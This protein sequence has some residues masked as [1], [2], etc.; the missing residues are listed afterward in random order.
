MFRFCFNVA[1]LFVILVGFS[2]FTAGSVFVVGRYIEELS[3]PVYQ[4]ASSATYYYI[5]GHPQ[6]DFMQGAVE[7]ARSRH[8][9]PIEFVEAIP[10]DVAVTELPCL[11][12]RDKDGYEIV[13]SRMTCLWSLYDVY[14]RFGIIP[15]E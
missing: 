8:N 2:T 14:V 13:E 1:R 12:F 9:L 10:S 7:L 4:P 6:C 15:V 5:S 3:K 11:I